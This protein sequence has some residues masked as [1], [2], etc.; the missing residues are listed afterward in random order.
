MKKIACLILSI[1]MLILLVSCLDNSKEQDEFDAYG[2]QLKKVEYVNGILRKKTEYHYENA[3]CS[4]YTIYEYDEKGV[5][6][7]SSHYVYDEIYGYSLYEYGDNNK[8][9]KMTNYDKNDTVIGYEETLESYPDGS[10]K[11]SK[12]HF[13]DNGMYCITEYDKKGN[14]LKQTAY[15]SDGSC[16]YSWVWEYDKNGNKIKFTNYNADATIAEYMEMEYYTSGIEKRCVGYDRSGNIKFIEEYHKNGDIIKR[17]LYNNDTVIT[18]KYSYNEIGQIAEEILYENN[19]LDSRK[20]YKYDEKRNHIK[21]ITTIYNSD[22]NMT[23]Y[24]EYEYDENGNLKFSTFFDK[25]GNQI[26]HDDY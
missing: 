14:M 13:N 3:K 22:G 21:T 16:V 6:T 4:S 5:L 20:E 7:K 15:D 26:S 1:L 12:L 2:N 10:A 11:V 24:A 19:V 23:G 8:L 9:L 18:Y 17:T 25:D